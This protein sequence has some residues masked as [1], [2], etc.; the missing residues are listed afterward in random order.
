MQLNRRQLVTGA[1]GA[2]AVGRAFAAKSGGYA[3]KP[4]T[5]PSMED[6]ARVAALPVLKREEFKTPVIIKSMEL[7]ELDKEYFVR[8]R[9]TDGAEGISVCNPP[10]A[11]YFGAVFK[12]LLVPA[13]LKQDARDLENVMWE[14]YRRGDNYKLYGIALW[15]PMAWAEMAI[16]DMLGRIAGKSIGQLLGEVRR[17]EIAMYVASGRRDT[18]PEQEIEYLRSLV[19]K[20]GAKALKFRLGGRMSKNADAMPGRTST[21]IPLVRKTF[22]DDFDLH[23]DSNSSYD[24]EHA[25]PVGRMLEEYKYVYYEE[26]CEFDALEDAKK[27]RDTLAIPIALG[28]QEYSEWRFRWTIANRICD[29]VQPDL[30]YYGGLIRSMRVARMAGLAKMPTVVHVS[31]GFGFVY[32]LHFASVVPDIGKYQE[33]KLG[34]EKY[35]AWFDP[36]ITVKN[37]LMN[38]PTAPGVGIKDP[39][40]L[41][42]NAKAA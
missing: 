26:S 20:S 25:I 24:P 37:G 14:A 23:G 27:V 32:S 10:R 19:E 35:G 33:Y 34:M 3:A 31:G 30:Y 7:L 29:I 4:H 42:K 15:S 1:I 11:D 39:V 16:L 22:G 9:S 28:E 13:F 2:V 6:L 38:V 41:L 36:P 18:T 17:K 12:D 40:A 8:V 21:L 5:A